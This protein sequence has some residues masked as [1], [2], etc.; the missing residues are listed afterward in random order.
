M[1]AVIAEEIMLAIAKSA[2]QAYRDGLISGATGAVTPDQ[3]FSE[4]KT[5]TDKITKIRIP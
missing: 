4:E 2:I 3:I 5:V 1:T